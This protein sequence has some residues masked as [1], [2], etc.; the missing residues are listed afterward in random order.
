LASPSATGFYGHSYGVG[1]RAIMMAGCRLLLVGF[2]FHAVPCGSM[3]L[4][5]SRD[6]HLRKHRR[7]TLD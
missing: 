1:D 4:A 7:R 2:S 6:R 5:E 3:P